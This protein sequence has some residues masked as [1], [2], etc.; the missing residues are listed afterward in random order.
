MKLLT[1]EL[2]SS[3]EDSVSLANRRFP[4]NRML[5]MSQLTSLGRLS[6][7]HGFLTAVEEQVRLVVR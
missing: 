6:C 5:V 1:T 7:Q 4:Y 3:P 2:S